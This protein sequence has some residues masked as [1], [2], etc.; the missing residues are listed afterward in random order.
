MNY[1]CEQHPLLSIFWC[2]ATVNLEPCMVISPIISTRRGWHSILELTR[3]I[4]LSSPA[5]P[6]VRDNP[7]AVSGEYWRSAKPCD[8]TEQKWWEKQQLSH[9]P[10][11][12]ER[13]HGFEPSS[14]AW[15]AKPY[16]S[17][18][19]ALIGS[20]E[21]VINALEKANWCPAEDFSP[22]R[23]NGGTCQWRSDYSGMQN[24]R[25]TQRRTKV[26]FYVF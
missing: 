21:F 15:K 26:P 3:H 18:Y 4:W 25:F 17:R 16:P 7:G 9:N 13:S 11:K 2:Y 12:M 24:Q 6:E 22:T 14:L 1:R 5:L 20:Q 10:Q 23:L 19:A 8:L